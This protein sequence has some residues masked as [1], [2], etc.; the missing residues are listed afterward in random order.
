MEKKHHLT[1]V[2]AGNMDLRIKA[3]DSPV[4]IEFLELEDTHT[5]DQGQVP[6]P[7]RTTQ[8]KTI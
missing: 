8:N 4:I 6:A 5:D 3:G 7:H 1:C 2:A